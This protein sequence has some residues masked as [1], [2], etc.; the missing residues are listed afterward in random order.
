M[1]IL[2]VDDS[3]FAR[4]RI[5]KVLKDAGHEVFETENGEGALRLAEEIRPQVVTVDLLM[6]GM[7]GIEVVR[8]LKKQRPDLRIV[9]V[10]ADIQKETRRE[11]LAAGAS[12]FV[13]KTAAEEVLLAALE[14]KPGGL[15]PMV[16]TD[17]QRD[18][19]TE[20]MNIAMGKA[21]AALS[22]LLQR[23]VRLKMPEVEVMSTEALTAF[24]REEIGGVGVMIR[25]DFFGDF[26]GKA[27]LVFSGGHASFLV[28]KLTD[29]QQELGSLS[30][31]EQTV[32]E[33]IGNIVLNAAVAVLADQCRKRVRMNLPSVSMHLKG[34]EAA[35]ELIGT[36]NGAQNAIVLI[37]RLSI[38]EWEMIGYLILLLDEED[39]GYILR[40]VGV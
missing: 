10:S 27:S 29:L 35:R 18:A 37:S 25:Q 34:D 19:F 38:G 28:R 24:F 11:T 6:P 8:R 3:A 33:E 12:A 15:V 40:I 13:S 20:V 4:Q 16:L 17:A 21:A 5:G 31:A 23:P 14:E 1:K 30:T 2:V 36:E 32:L 26:I 7:N 9:V 39:V 22:V